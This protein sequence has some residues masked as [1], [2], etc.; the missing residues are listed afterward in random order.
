[1]AKH[2]HVHDEN[3]NHEGHSH[4]APDAK[5]QEKY[6]ELQ[7]THM[8]IKQVQE[9]LY[10]LESQAMQV[11]ETKTNLDELKQVAKETVILAPIAQGMFVKAKLLEPDSIIVHAGSDAFMPKTTEEAK[12]ML[13]EQSGHIKKAQDELN[14]YL[15]QYTQ[16]AQMLEKE[17]MQMM[18]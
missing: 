12:K 7:S 9:Q 4:A 11:V 16:E 14:A 5:V 18:K 13:S 8:R 1:M 6:S 17:I 2:E 3:C 15:K 10:A